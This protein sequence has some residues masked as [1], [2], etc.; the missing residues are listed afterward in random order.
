MATVI[1]DD[2]IG[3]A[4]GTL[5]SGL[6]GSP[7]D[8]WEAYAFKQRVAGQQ[9]ANA[10]AQIEL[11]NL[12]RQRQ[13]QDSFLSAS[14][15]MFQPG[16]F[17]I[18]PVI[19]APR[20][21]PMF[22]GPMPG[23]DNPADDNLDQK[24]QFARAASRN[25]ILRGGTPDQALSAA[26]GS[27]GMGNILAGGV[28]TDE[29]TARQ[30]QTFLTGEIPDAK[31][32]LTEQQRVRMVEE[33]NAAK[34]AEAGA[35]T[36]SG[37]F[38]SGSGL[39]QQ[40]YNILLQRD[41][42]V[43]SG[44]PVPPE[45][46]AAANA[47]AHALAKS[48]TE[49]RNGPDGGVYPVQIPGSLPPGIS[50][51]G[52]AAAPAPAPAPA[53]AAA[54][55][56]PIPAPAPVPGA[57]APAPGASGI[58]VGEPIIPGKPTPPPEHVSRDATFI[59]V[60]DESLG[61]MTAMLAEGYQPT[62]SGSMLSRLANSASEQDG[63]ADYAI[64]LGAAQLRGTVDPK[65]QQFEAHRM[66][67]LNAVLRDES[68]AAVPVSEYPKYISALIPRYGDDPATITIKQR[69]M[70]M[71][72]QARRSGQTLSNITAI[73]LGGNPAMDAL[74]ARGGAGGAPAPQGNPDQL[75]VLERQKVDAV[76]ARIQGSSLPPTVKAQRIQAAEQ[77][78]QQAIGGM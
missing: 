23:M 57:P 42:L 75:R 8:K 32:A 41:A 54:T 47:A 11:A 31:T 16:N 2:S 20:P 43:R 18:P 65:G 17:N 71:A 52:Q 77:R 30:T 44:Q 36:A 56:G 34:A 72:L 37:E 5:A 14:D 28:P 78:F 46:E 63:I 4:L 69:K 66:T 7:K 39:E 26:Y 25:A 19:E 70:A 59:Q 22:P 60:M 38:F 21:S 50:V 3:Q 67:F 61:G 10:A 53:P 24:L 68:G 51:P 55:P 58:T 29:A 49:F 40:A 74:D 62:F 73:A 6:M 13:A 64:Q 9:T 33:E 1:R 76:I 27:L 12:Q 45:L 48:R 15:A 35:D